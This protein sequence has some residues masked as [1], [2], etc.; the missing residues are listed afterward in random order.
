MS[1]MPG[2]PPMMPGQPPMGGG[3]DQSPAAQMLP[4]LAMLAQ[5]QQQALAIQD[6]QEQMLKEAM[7][8]QLLRL[9]SMMPAL[10]PAGVAARTEPLPPNIS[11]EDGGEMEN[12]GEMEDDTMEMD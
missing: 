6:Q 1:A 9:I 3:D 5:Q 12:E 2:Q 7:K 10:N 8:Q 11:P 4:P